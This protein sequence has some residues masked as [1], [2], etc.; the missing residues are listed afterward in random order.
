MATLHDS[1]F[2]EASPDKVWDAAR[3]VGALHTRLVPGFVVDTKLDG[4]A[5][6]VTF[7]NG[8]T[9]REPIISIDDERRR[10]AWGASG[11]KTTHY[12]AVLEVRPEGEGARVTWTIDLLP[13]EMTSAIRGMQAQGLAIMKKTLEAAS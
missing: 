7:G 10:L 6:V 3:D 1:V 8:L 13:N 9:A 12:N 2:I 5:R 4:D 11:G